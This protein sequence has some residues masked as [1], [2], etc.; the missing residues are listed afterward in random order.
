MGITKFQQSFSG[1]EQAPVM[2]GRADDKKY[3]QGLATCRNFITLPQGPAVNRPGFAFVRET[4][5]PDK[6]SRLIEFVYSSDQ[7]MVLEF[8]DKYIRFHTHGGTLLGS[9]GQPYEVV[10]P[11][12]AED[13]FGINHVQSADVMTLVHNR[14][15]P[16]ELRRYGATDW[17]L[18]DVKLVEDLGAPVISSVD[19]SC[20]EKDA[21]E[22]EKTRY[23][24]SY[25]VTALMD[26]GTSVYEGPASEAKDTKGNLYINSSFTTIKWGA[27]PN[28]NR[29]RVYKS[30][31]GLYAYIGE[32]EETSFIDDNYEPDVGITPSLRRD[33]FSQ[34]GGI[35]SVTVTNQGS[36]YKG[37][38]AVTE[39][40]PFGTMEQGDVTSTVYLPIQVAPV[41]PMNV[42]VVDTAAAVPGAGATVSVVKDDLDGAEIRIK[43]F[44]VV[45]GGTGYR[46]PEVHFTAVEWLKGEKKFKF[47][48]KVD[49]IEDD[50][51]KVY[52]SDATGKGAVL[53][54][55][56]SGDKIVGIKVVNPGSG[57]TSPTIT[58]VSPYGSGATA[59]AKVGAAGDYPA[60]VAYF[61]QRRCFGGTNNSPQTIWMTRSGTESD[62]SYTIPSKDDNRIEFRIVAQ[63]AAK[64]AHMVPLS[65]LV[66]LTNST[67]F[68]VSSGGSNA[69]SPTAIQVKPQAYNG[70]SGVQPVVVNT[71]MVYAAARGGH[72]MELGYNWQA[73]GFISGDLCV[74]AS[75]LFQDKRVV[76]MAFARAPDPIVWCAMSDGS[77]QGL[78][79]MPEQSVGGWHRHDTVDGFFESVAVVTEGD[80]DILYAIVRRGVGDKEVRYVE[81]MSE[82]KLN[83]LVEAF[84]V[85][86]GA[87][88]KGEPTKTIRGL[89][90]LEGKEVSI[91]A[92]GCVL[93]RKTV[94]G[95]TIEID[96]EASFITIGLPI[97]ADLATLPV[98]LTGQT[99]VMVD[100]LKNVNEVWV[101][102][103]QSSGVFA[104]PTFDEL[105]EYKQRAGEPYGT[106][107]QLVS[108]EVSIAITPAW[109]DT[110]TVCIRQS[111]PLPLTV[112]SITYDIAS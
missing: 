100:S 24:L 79:Y 25:K 29:Y 5:F 4:K 93:P 65:Q 42:T 41:N 68:I 28:A 106:P 92:D 9:D 83:S 19:Y 54:A 97:S 109:V 107:P 84:Y 98:V 81:R 66:V 69:L 104:G 21:T 6:P 30:Y 40:E 71:T 60:A 50:I 31:K 58:I 111:D 80:E 73:G 16:K 57:Y 20:G 55:V 27:V 59:T 108:K 110:G 7:T 70:A 56:R 51:V 87:T 45:T 33:I 3:Q 77:L 102:V 32:T 1:G 78:T 95:G 63:Q 52:V 11:Y 74:R 86:C 89:D 88:Y 15:Y 18:V 49:S 14:Y 90:Y 112:V 17:R 96:R 99:G 10:T 85:D 67:E 44:N 22:E 8:G 72:V 36:G 13:L 26:Q 91:L 101:R 46:E 105:T 53:K 75:H 43:G 62:M 82:R 2:Y 64:V 38:G 34:T 94:K 37:P 47:K 48:A 61:E 12:E 103:Y 39:V 35:Q 23:T 76:D